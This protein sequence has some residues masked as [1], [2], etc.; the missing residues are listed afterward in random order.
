M[1]REVAGEAVQT[2]GLGESVGIIRAVYFGR[3]EEEAVALL[4]ETNYAGFYNYFAA[5]GSGKRSGCQKPRI[6]AAWCRA[7][8]IVSCKNSKQQKSV[9]NRPAAF[10]TKR[11]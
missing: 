2:L 5:S 8:L 1:S 6:S 4:R 3:T 10:R 7:R 11:V 9:P